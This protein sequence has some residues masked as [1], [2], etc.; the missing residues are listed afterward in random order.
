MDKIPQEYLQPFWPRET[1]MDFKEA[2]A[3][4]KWG[5]T[6]QKRERQNHFCTHTVFI[7]L[8]GPEITH[9]WG[10]SQK[11]VKDENLNWH[12][13]CCKMSSFSSTKLTATRA[14]GKQTKINSLAEFKRKY[15]FTNSHSWW[16]DKLQN[17]L[18]YRDQGICWLILKRK[19]KK[20]NP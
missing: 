17:Y 14:N 6:P 16:P 10:R 18:E 9:V 19:D 20:P 8:A 2:T 1:R 7:Y 4:G 13:S 15:V 11:S 3:P 12:L 5:T